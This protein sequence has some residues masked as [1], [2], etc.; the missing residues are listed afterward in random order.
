MESLS[1]EYLLGALRSS[2]LV[3]ISLVWLVSSPGS[4]RRASFPI[5]YRKKHQD[6][7]IPVMMEAMIV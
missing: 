1:N 6:A 3:W 4:T 5:R 2:S 7:R